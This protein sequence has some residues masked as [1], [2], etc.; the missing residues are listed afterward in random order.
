MRLRLLGVATVAIATL[1]SCSDGAA[2][3]TTGAGAQAPTSTTLATTTTTRASTTTTSEPQPAFDGVELA[4]GAIDAWN[5]GDFDA[6]LAY[7]EPDQDDDFFF[8]RSVMN[9]NERVEVTAPCE[10]TSEPSEPMVVTCSI[11]VEDD[12]HGAGGLTS[13]AIKQ[14]H[15]NGEGF[16]VYTTSTTYQ[17]EN[18]AC[19]PQ[20]QAIH[21]AFHR[22]LSDAHPDVYEEIGPEDGNP[23]WYLP[24]VASGNPDHMLVALEYVEEF[25]AQSAAYPLGG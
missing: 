25:V 13:N 15:F 17:D 10:I 19:C 14:F 4:M 11:H 1:A 12:F 16:I 3:D 2:S 5:S 20:W 6:W 23:L 21:T 22:W 24:G 8:D 7:W 9:S 18:G